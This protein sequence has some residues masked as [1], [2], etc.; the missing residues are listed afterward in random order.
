MCDSCARSFGQS[1]GSVE[2]LWVTPN[3]VL[4]R[5]CW[6]ELK[7][8]GG[9]NST[10]ARGWKIFATLAKFKKLTAMAVLWRGLKISNVFPI[11]SSSQT[12]ASVRVANIFPLIS[13]SPTSQ[14]TYSRHIFQSRAVNSVQN[15]AHFAV[16]KGCSTYPCDWQI[17]YIGSIKLIRKLLYTFD[18]RNYF[19]NI[20]V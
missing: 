12:L 10:G 5:I 6:P 15:T 19:V 1:H 11:I 8:T 7:Q 14:Y 16:M 4:S 2:P 3:A 20:T 17:D 18:P 13:A 9:Y